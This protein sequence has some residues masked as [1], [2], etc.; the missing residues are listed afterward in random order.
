[1][2]R[3]YPSYYNKRYNAYP[4][5]YQNLSPRTRQLL[6][7]PTI[8]NF[9]NGLANVGSNLPDIISPIK[10]GLSNISNSISYHTNNIGGNLPDIASPIANILNSPRFSPRSRRNTNPRRY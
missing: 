10:Y 7:M 3:T 8:D 9:R 2:P 6:I 4:Q 1:M 5:S